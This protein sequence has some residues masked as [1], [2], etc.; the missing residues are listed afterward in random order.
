MTKRFLQGAVNI[1][2][3]QTD[4]RRAGTPAAAGTGWGFAAAAPIV[5]GKVS[6]SW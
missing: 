4:G 5:P 3:T 6:S 2:L 1:C